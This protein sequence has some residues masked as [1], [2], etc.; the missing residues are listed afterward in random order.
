MGRDNK[1]KCSLDIL[2]IRLIIHTQHSFLRGLSRS[3]VKSSKYQFILY[4]L[5]IQ[6]VQ[7]IKAHMKQEFSDISIL[8]LEFALTI[9]V[10]RLIS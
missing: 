6:D 9:V 4:E 7:V 8:Y 10:E 3:E 1:V 2:T 5:T